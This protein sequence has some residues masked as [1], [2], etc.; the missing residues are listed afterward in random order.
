M[1]SNRSSSSNGG[2]KVLLK[3]H[4]YHRTISNKIKCTY[5]KFK[6]KYESKCHVI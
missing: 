2:G 4:M 6:Y 3:I 1:Y 5:I